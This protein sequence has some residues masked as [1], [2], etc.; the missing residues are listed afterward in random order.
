MSSL[1]A[2]NRKINRLYE[3]TAKQRKSRTP[4][5]WRG[6]SLMWALLSSVFTYGR[7]QTNSRQRRLLGE[8]R[9]PFDGFLFVVSSGGTEII[10]KH[11]G[12]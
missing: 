10:N 11:P 7:Y 1:L 8:T 6:S 5:R 2:L 9:S 4:G 12:F 3:R